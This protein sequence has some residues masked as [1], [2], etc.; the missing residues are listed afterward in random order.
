MSLE[1]TVKDL[2]SQKEKTVGDAHARS[3]GVYYEVGFHYGWIRYYCEAVYEGQGKQ[4][5][6][7]AADT[8]EEAQMIAELDALCDIRN[9]LARL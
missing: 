7:K 8:F 6:Y 4:K 5:F 1:W 2:P 9:E 3:K